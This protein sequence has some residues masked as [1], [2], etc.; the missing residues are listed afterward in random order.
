MDSSNFIPQ[1][2]YWKQMFGF[3]ENPEDVYKKLSIESGPDE[4]SKFIYSHENNRSFKCGDFRTV[5]ISE[6]PTYPPALS[7]GRFFVISGKGGRTKNIREIDVGALQANPNNK[8][9][10]FQVASNFNCLEFVS[11]GD[12]ARRGITSYIFDPTQGPAAS[13]SCGAATAY[14]NYFVPHTPEGRQ[15][16]Y[17]GQLERQINLLER[18]PLIPITNG[19]V[20]FSE[21]TQLKLQESAFDF[22]DLSNIKVGVHNDIQVTSGLK[23]H[24]EVEVVRDRDQIV[25]QVFTAAM[26][27]SGLNRGET[28]RAVARFLLH[29]AYRGT[30]LSAIHNSHRLAHTN[31]PG[32]NKLFLTLIGGGVFGNDIHWIL[33]AIKSCGDLIVSSGMEIYLVNYDSSHFTH[34]QQEVLKEIVL[35]HHGEI[36][37]IS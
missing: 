37:E 16:T 36:R 15:K 2:R 7:P 22:K 24:G 21:K 25:N 31:W 33:E 5:A 34:S 27:L 20:T 12:S 29:G 6:F 8:G 11:P 18:I 17:V 23:H 14:R 19:Y 10:T 35:R 9:A 30:F 32:K 4:E 3:A 1:E 13:I 28:C 26:N